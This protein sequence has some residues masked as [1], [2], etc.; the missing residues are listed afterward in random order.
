MPNIGR[1]KTYTEETRRVITV[2]PVSLVDALDEEVER[3][4][5]VPNTGRW[6]RNGLILDLIKRGLLKRAVRSVVVKQREE[7]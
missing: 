3:L 7:R 6:S 5:R 2:I 4:K 1:P